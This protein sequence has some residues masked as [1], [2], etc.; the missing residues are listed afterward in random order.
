GYLLLHDRF[1]TKQELS[2][3]FLVSPSTILG[4]I[5]IIKS[6]L[7]EVGL[8]LERKSQRGWKVPVKSNNRISL[9]IKVFGPNNKWLSNQLNEKIEKRRIEEFTQ[10]LFELLSNN[11]LEI[12]HGSFELLTEWASMYMLFNYLNGEKEN[13]S[14]TV[15]VRDK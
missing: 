1:V 15:K 12:I 2:N 3:L 7:K 11:D 14:K 9:L 13:Y 8:V 5:D 6:H 10:S 4:H